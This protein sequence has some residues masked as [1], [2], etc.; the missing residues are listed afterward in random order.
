MPASKPELTG[1]QL[2]LR[3]LGY[4]LPYKWVFGAAVIGMIAGAG[5]ET[6]F[7]AL[8]KPIMDGGFVERDEAFIK[9]IPTCCATSDTSDSRGCCCLLTRT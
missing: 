9:L 5:A 8:L 4:A 7:A 3:L 6:A 2:Y 1:Y